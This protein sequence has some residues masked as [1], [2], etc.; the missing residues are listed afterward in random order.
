MTD[1]GGTFLKQSGI[2]CE[3]LVGFTAGL[4]SVLFYECRLHFQ[5]ATCTFLHWHF[6]SFRFLISL[7]IYIYQTWLEWEVKLSVSRQ[8]QGNSLWQLPVVGSGFT[9]FNNH[10]SWFMFSYLIIIWMLPPLQR[11]T[12]LMPAFCSY[13]VKGYHD[14]VLKELILNSVLWEQSSPNQTR[15]LIM[16]VPA[17]ATA[18]MSQILIYWTRGENTA[19]LNRSSKHF[20]CVPLRFPISILWEFNLIPTDI[21]PGTVFQKKKKIGNKKIRTDWRWFFFSF[22]STG[23]FGYLTLPLCLLVSLPVS[24]SIFAEIILSYF[25]GFWPCWPRGWGGFYGLIPHKASNNLSVH[26]QPTFL[27]PPYYPTSK[28]R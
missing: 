6:S 2:A 5:E 24:Q 3:N 19:F 13:Q 10:I 4:T 16:I 7:Y 27:P 14:Y 17:Y 28:S 23:M 11:P 8:P 12:R 20:R 21:S 9:G 22:K 25:L 1:S 26:P 18:H 15:S